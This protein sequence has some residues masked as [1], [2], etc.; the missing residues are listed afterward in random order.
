MELTATHAIQGLIMLATI[1]S[2]YAIVKNNLSRVME[3]LENFHVAFDK[4]K[5][6]FDTRLDDA[7]SQRAVFSSQISVLKE[8]NSVKSLETR[9]R[10]IATMRAELR[11]L[12]DQVKHLQH[13]HNSK[14]P[15]QD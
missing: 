2:G 4:F 9:N 11:V 12:Q 13:I 5:A 15:K 8:I 6:S 7:E 3:D 10:E 1:A 14:H